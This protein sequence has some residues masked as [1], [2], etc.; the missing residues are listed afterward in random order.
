M[1]KN[2]QFNKINVRRNNLEQFG[3]SAELLSG[4]YFL[5]QAGG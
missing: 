4:S 1:N 3:A 2:E 5:S